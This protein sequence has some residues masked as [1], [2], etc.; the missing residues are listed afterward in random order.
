MQTV[1]VAV[2]DY[3]RRTSRWHCEPR[4]ARHRPSAKTLHMSVRDVQDRPASHGVAIVIGDRS[5]RWHSHSQ[6]LDC[7][8]S[9]RAVR[10]QCRHVRARIVALDDGHGTRRI[11]GSD[12]EPTLRLVRDHIERRR[13]FGNPSCVA[14]FMTAVGSN[15]QR[16][17]GQSPSAGNL[18]TTI[19][20]TRH[21]GAG[22]FAYLSH[23]SV[24]SRLTAFSVMMPRHRPRISQ[25]RQA[26]RAG[27]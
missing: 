13:P 9:E 7:A 20:A 2:S 27:L 6:S 3:P 16:G 1:C 18:R 17:P 26:A 21:V 25:R 15:S 5:T 11:A 8:L 22:M 24:A 23:F 4:R 14:T 19:R 12:H 10:L